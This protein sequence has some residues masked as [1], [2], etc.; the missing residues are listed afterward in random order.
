MADSEGQLILSR[1]V[2]DY[3]HWKQIDK[4]HA[5]YKN[6][7]TGQIYIGHLT[8]LYDNEAD[9]RTFALMVN[10]AGD[11]AANVLNHEN[12]VSIHTEI[13]EQQWILSKGA[14]DELLSDSHRLILY[15]Y[16][17][18]GT[19]QTLLRRPPVARTAHGPFMPESLCWH[20]ATSLI[21]ALQWLHEGIRDIYDV[22]ENRQGRVWWA[23]Q[24]RCIRVRVRS[25]P[26]VGW[27]PI[28][29]RDIRAENIMM[30]HPKGI[31]TYGT[32]KLGGFRKCVVTGGILHGDGVGKEDAVALAWE[33]KWDTWNDEILDPGIVRMREGYG[34]WKQQGRAAEEVRAFI[35]IF[36]VFFFIYFFSFP[37]LIPKFKHCCVCMCALIAY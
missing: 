25:E 15:D 5:Y 17:D 37:L 23:D 27:L 9:R 30:S 2:S 35:F 32:V 16:C 26:Q 12:L 11:A 13:M 22:A 36:I 6:K 4:T 34:R 31:E 33:K 19:L 28:L 21:R 3:V 29:H 1:P 20:V 10:G 18:A 14:D 24:T 7:L 8:N